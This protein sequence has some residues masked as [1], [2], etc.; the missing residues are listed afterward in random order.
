MFRAVTDPSWAAITARVMARPGP[1]SCTH[2]D[3]PPGVRAMYTS[4]VCPLAVALAHAAVEVRELVAG[5]A[6]QVGGDGEGAVLVGLHHLVEAVG[7]DVDDGAAG[8]GGRGEPEQ[9]V[10]EHEA[11]LELAADAGLAG[12]EAQGRVPRGQVRH[13]PLEALLEAVR[14]AA[15]VVLLRDP[16][17]GES[18]EGVA[19]GAAAWLGVGGDGEAVQGLVGGATD[20]GGLQEPA[21]ARLERG[22]GGLV[23]GPLEDEHLHR[24]EGLAGL[25]AVEGLHDPVGE[26]DTGEPA[27]VLFDPV[28]GLEDGAELAGCPG[29]VGGRGHVVLDG[30]GRRCKLHPRRQDR[31]PRGL[32]LG[33]ARAGADRREAGDGGLDARVLG[34][35]GVEVGDA[36]RRLSQCLLEGLVGEGLGGEGLGGQVADLGGTPALARVVGVG[37]VDLVLHRPANALVLALDLLDEVAE[38]PTGAVLQGVP[39]GVERVARLAGADGRGQVHDDVG[40]EVAAPGALLELEEA[41]EPDTA[42]ISG[43]SG[44]SRGSTPEGEDALGGHDARVEAVDEAGQ[45]AAEAEGGGSGSPT[46]LS[47]AVP[48]RLRSHG[49]PASAS[50]FADGSLICRSPWHLGA[51]PPG[52][53]NHL[54]ATGKAATLERQYALVV[55]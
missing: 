51:E 4:T 35:I 1:L 41:A 15:V 54:Q 43:R 48:P 33:G 12:H 2:S 24:A 3:T 32:V 26:H 13:P 17:P 49:R 34:A 5:H 30:H 47:F 42:A 37:V 21:A 28:G 31:A 38:G 52:R 46:P 44:G 40:L 39:G 16:Q 55:A 8:A 36:A 11:W 23:G 29:A 6:V 22:V 14:P 18:A 27:R 25:G 10:V 50:G 19:L 20:A 53:A 9:L 7:V 45:G